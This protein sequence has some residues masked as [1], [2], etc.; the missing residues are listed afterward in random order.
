M[1]LS[2]SSWFLDLIFLFADILSS[3]C[4]LHACECADVC[5][6]MC[7]HMCTWWWLLVRGKWMSSSNPGSEK[8]LVVEW[9][10]TDKPSLINGRNFGVHIY[11]VVWIMEHVFSWKRNGFYSKLIPD[12]AHTQ[13]NRLTPT[14][15][16][17]TLL[18]LL[19]LLLL[20][21]REQLSMGTVFRVLQ[22]KGESHWL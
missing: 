18:L 14:V 5:L 16:E 17:A 15:P 20:I 9:S 3:L 7:E 1:D 6:H 22:F 2:F 11:V 10:G 21:L 19:L 4:G 12:L 13:K 8:C